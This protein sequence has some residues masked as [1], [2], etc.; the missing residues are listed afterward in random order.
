[1]GTILPLS[2]PYIPQES[3]VASVSAAMLAALWGKWLNRFLCVIENKQEF[4]K[5][6]SLTKRGISNIK[7]QQ[8]VKAFPSS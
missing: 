6:V 8:E 4:C 1:M 7:L 2:L 5:L 3:N